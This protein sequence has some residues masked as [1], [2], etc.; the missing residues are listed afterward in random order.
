MN[1]SNLAPSTR[2][3]NSSKINNKPDTDSR[4]IELNK[5]GSVVSPDLMHDNTFMKYTAA[6]GQRFL[7]NILTPI[8]WENHSL[9]SLVLDNSNNSRTLEFKFNTSH[10][11]VDDLQ[12][13]DKSYVINAGKIIAFF[14]TLIN[15]KFYWRL[16]SETNN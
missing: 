5:Y 16:S 6:P 3:T 4:E 10:S 12:N 9:H 13:T 2:N 11:L 7:V 8:N 1:N 15:G 14:G